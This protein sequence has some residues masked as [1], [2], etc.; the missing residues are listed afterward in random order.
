[1][2]YIGLFSFLLLITSI[3]PAFALYESPTQEEKNIFDKLLVQFEA[4]NAT[5]K[6]ISDVIQTFQKP[7]ISTFLCNSQD[8]NN[9]IITIVK[10][11]LAKFDQSTVHQDLV[12]GGSYTWHCSENMQS[13]K[14]TLDCN[15]ELRINPTVISNDTQIDPKLHDIENLV[16]LYHELLHGQLM[17]DA[18]KSSPLWQQETCNIKPKDNID[19]SYADPDHKIINYLQ[20]QFASELVDKDGGKMIT[21]EIN[22]SETKNGTFTVKVLSFQDY[23]TFTNGAKITLRTNNILE[24]SF[25]QVKNDVFLSGHLKDVTKS[26]LAWFYL[27]NNEKTQNVTYEP[28]PAWAKRVAGLWASGN[29]DDRDFF[30]LIDYLVQNK[31]I[32]SISEKNTISTMPHWFKKNANLW[33]NGEIDDKTFLSS[34][35]YLISIGI[36]N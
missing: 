13:G 34:T 27:F 20:T 29:T 15:N 7:L 30:A 28:V 36:I 10:T 17:I 21:K 19:Y 32:N 23:P 5:K 25:F 8:T 1:L 14:V 26:G 24:N 33:F 31:I 2:K 22:P 9:Q 4:I 12:T 18:V 16:I 6:D 3:T 35:Q 11:K